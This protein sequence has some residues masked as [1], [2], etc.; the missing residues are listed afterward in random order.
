MKKKFLIKLICLILVIPMIL[1]VVAC[2]DN[3]SNLG[4]S[5]S[6]FSNY[7]EGFDFNSR[8]GY[9][10]NNGTS[11]YKILIPTDA[12]LAIQQAAN[13][14]VEYTLK[15]TGVNVQIVTD[16]AYSETSGYSYFSIGNTVLKEQ[17]RLNTDY[18]TLNGDGFVIKT[19]NGHIIV[20]AGSNSG[21][22]YGTYDFIEKVLG[23]RF[24]AYDETYVPSQSEVKIYKMDY[25][26]VP[27]FASRIYLSQ[28]VYKRLADVKWAAHSRTNSYW[29]NT[30][31]RYGYVSNVYSRK[32]ETHN[33]RYYV[34]AEKYGS[35]EIGYSG[36]YVEGH[37]EHNELYYVVPGKTPD[38]AHGGTSQGNVTINWLSG[39]TEDGKLDTS[40]EI[41]TAKVVI[42]EMKKDV[43]ANPHAEYF[44]L[45][46][47]DFYDIV[48]KN[49][50]MVQKYGASG[51]VV[52][53][54]NVVAT[55]IQKWADAELNG[56]KI[57]IC[58]FAYQQS[59]QA[60]VI[61]NSKGEYEPID[62]TVVPVENLCIRLALTSEMFFGYDDE[63]QSIAVKGTF[64]RW[65]A[66]CDHFWFWGY[67]TCYNDYVFY[68]PSLGSAY[69]TVQYMRDLGVVNF[70]MQ[71]SYNTAGDW[72]SLM[73]SYVWS[74]LLWNPDQDVSFLVDEFLNGYYGVA[75]PYIR[76]MMNGLDAHFAKY[77]LKEE[78]RPVYFW[79]YGTICTDVNVSATVLETAI[80]VLEKAEDAINND[81]NLTYTNKQKLIK[82]LASV[83]M[84]PKWMQL[85]F[86]G[87]L[88]P[89]AD[90]RAKVNLAQEVLDLSTLSG[91]ESF[92][93]TT[94]I[95]GYLALHYGVS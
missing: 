45:D 90:Q 78:E 53:F 51:V 76:E 41:S 38:Y 2:N 81:N 26:S 47:E 80:A 37:E 12:P 71:S 27:A 15:S 30:G 55:E 58:T 11:N 9:F 89:L 93:E 75:A 48:P 46:Q 68:C 69:G 21:F 86:Y 25:K 50:P 59:Q 17:A 44:V 19:Y 43:L 85:K 94:S 49:H 8:I 66:I 13:E 54:C 42:E 52:R 1:G 88:Y 32:A 95:S 83:Q 3:T 4:N 16:S 24:L 67:D 22:L 65:S 73:K 39:I 57:N 29:L 23:V 7:Y 84:T 87:N 82:R 92:S 40:M 74:K 63:R 35:A 56:R 70:L 18:S 33:S 28:P 61:K 72:Q 64:D 10:V 34:P 6:K 31:E 62:Q 20:D 60:P 77:M 36:E 14:L 5:N 91:F 79:P